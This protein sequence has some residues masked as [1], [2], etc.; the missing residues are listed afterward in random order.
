MS[1]PVLLAFAAFVGLLV[2][3]LLYAQYLTRW[4][5]DLRP[6][7]PFWSGRS[8]LFLQRNV[9][10]L[11]NYVPEARGKARRLLGLSWTRL[12]AS[13]VFYV[14]LGRLVLDVFG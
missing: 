13:V 2:A 14:L 9:S 8:I 1:I 4:R 5:V 3:E 6:G 11:E 12:A 10:R 7:E